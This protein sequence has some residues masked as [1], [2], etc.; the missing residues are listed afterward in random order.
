[1]RGARAAGLGL[2]L[3]GC[4]ATMPGGAGDDSPLTGHFRNVEPVSV[5][6]AWRLALAEGPV[7]RL[8]PHELG[9]PAHSA[10]LDRV[11]V[12][13]A[14]GEVVCARA[15]NGE[16]LWRRRMDGAVSSTPVF[17]GRRVLLGTDDGQMLA[18]D[19]DSGEER[20]RYVVQG[21]I[22]EPPQ[23]VGDQV[24]FVDGTNSVYAVGRTDGAWRWQYRRTPPAD[25]S[26]SGEARP[27]VVE[28]RVFVGFSDGHLV[29]LAASDGAV[30]WTRDLAPEH[31]RFQDV[32]AAAVLL[33]GRLF[34]ASAATGI[35]ALRP[36]DGT[37][38]FTVP[39][40][41][42]NQLMV[43]GGSLIASVDRGE[44]WR[45]SSDGRVEWKTR[46]PGGAPSEAVALGDAL[47]VSMSQ[48]ALQFLRA[49]D[50]R[51]LQ[52][53]APGLGLAA[54]P[55]VATDGGLYVLS[56]AG[57]LYAFRPGA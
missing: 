28:G 14:S 40:A 39:V 54:A 45:V 46:L 21:A 25:F 9:T 18:L 41:G 30:L 11:V 22:Q 43:Q 16:V 38:L 27:L 37:I 12:G 53:F 4:G 31:D 55:G 17:D 35:H 7:Y 8:R 36:A 3:L 5:T 32:D 44:V 47:A 49:R 50:G 6:P 13:T 1:M 2:C 57:V 19:A 34:A 29:A 24:L 26:V 48:G 42:V 15:G 10:S 51:P 23:L 52:R 33:D 56:N 20:W